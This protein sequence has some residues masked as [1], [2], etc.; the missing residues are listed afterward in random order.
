MVGATAPVGTRGRTPGAAWPA[1]RIAA[2]SRAPSSP[3]TT[4]TGTVGSFGLR[5]ESSIAPTRWS[6]S[7][8]APQQPR[9]AYPGLRGAMA[10][11]PMAPLSSHALTASASGVVLA[12]ALPA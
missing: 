11:T 4:T 6:V 8:S 10:M 5:S 12:A 3:T 7:I 1:A 9:P 2:R